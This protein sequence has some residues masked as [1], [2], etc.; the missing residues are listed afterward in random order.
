M[1]KNNK[2]FEL[3][4]E[5]WAP[6]AQEYAKFLNRYGLQTV[7]IISGKT[8]MGALIKVF[9]DEDKYLE[10][11]MNNKQFNLEEKQ[12]SELLTVIETLSVAAFYEDEYEREYGQD[13]D[14]SA[15]EIEI[16]DDDES[17]YI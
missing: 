10:L 14:D 1:L 16:S 12:I 13:E 6:V 4:C 7:C 11:S 17:K 5:K 15:Y 8:F 3:I 9:A 2:K